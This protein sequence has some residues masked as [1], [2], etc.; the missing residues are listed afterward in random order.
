MSSDGFWVFIPK[1][2]PTGGGGEVICVVLAI[3]IGFFYW[4]YNWAIGWAT[5][6]FPGKLVAVIYYTTIVLPCQI[7][8]AIYRFINPVEAGGLTAY[9]N[10]NLAFGVVAFIGFIFL[11]IVIMNLF[12]KIFGRYA[13][14]LFLTYVFGPWLFWLVW[15]GG[16]W[17]LAK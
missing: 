8:V 13:S 6:A 5:Y 14:A 4:L 3:I 15:L 1:Q 16:E 2:A 12:F 17:L 10:L 7:A 11:F 9:P